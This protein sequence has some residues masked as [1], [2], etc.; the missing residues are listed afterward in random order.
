MAFLAGFTVFVLGWGLVGRGSEP[1]VASAAA[2][3][4]GHGETLAR[5]G[6]VEELFPAIGVVDDGPDGHGHLY[7][8]ALAT[9]PVTAFAV[10]ATFRVVLGVEAEM[11]KSV[12]VRVCDHDDV[13]AAATVSAARTAARNEFLTTKRETPV[14]AIACFYFDFYFVDK[15]C[16]KRK[17]PLG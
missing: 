15:H 1:R 5:L 2:S 9:S 10:A 17:R 14:A 12:V 3:T 13:P 16:W 8:V 7:V 6:E 4:F 11:Q